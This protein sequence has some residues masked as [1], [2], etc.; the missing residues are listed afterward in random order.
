M[1][2]IAANQNT[3]FARLCDAMGR[4]ELKDDPRYATHVARGENQ[5]EL[6]DL[7]NDWTKTRTIDEVEAVMIEHSRAGR[8]SLPGSRHAGRSALRRP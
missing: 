5:V 4:P 1:V 8:E 2:I 6:D 3:V 7:I